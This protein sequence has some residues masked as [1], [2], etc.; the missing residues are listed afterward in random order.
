MIVVIKSVKR[1]DTAVKYTKVLIVFIF[2]SAAYIFN[3]SCMA[4]TNCFIFKSD[5]IVYSRI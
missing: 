2:E 1:T 5:Y 3:L 4:V